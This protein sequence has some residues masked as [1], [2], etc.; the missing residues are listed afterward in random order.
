MGYKFLIVFAGLIFMFIGGYYSYVF[1]NKKIRESNGAASL[2]FYSVALFIAMGTVYFGGLFVIAKV[3][4]FLM[5][6]E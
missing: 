4:A 3:Y 2:L 1:L 5:S 6:I